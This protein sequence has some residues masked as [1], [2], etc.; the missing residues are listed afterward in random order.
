MDIL[1]QGVNLL[2]SFFVLILTILAVINFRK[3]RPF[4]PLNLIITI[5]LSMLTLLLYVPVSGIQVRFILGFLIFITGLFFGWVT[6]RTIQLEKVEQQ[7]I[8]RHSRISFLLWGL[9]LVFSML[10]NLAP[11]SLA[12]TLGALPLFLTTGMQVSANFIILRKTRKLRK[13]SPAIA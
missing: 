5:V 9:S 2:C 4:K 1:F 7:V 3:K 13:Q 8:G 6:G 11:G 10:M 12:S